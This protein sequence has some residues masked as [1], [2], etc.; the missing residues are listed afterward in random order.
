MLFNADLVEG[1]K[2]C[3]DP[4]CC[5]TRQQQHRVGGKM[6][7]IKGRYSSACSKKLRLKVSLPLKVLTLLSLVLSPLFVISSFDC[8]WLSKKREAF[9]QEDFP[10]LLRAEEALCLQFVLAKE[11]NSVLLRKKKF[12]SE[13]KNAGDAARFARND[14]GQ[15]KKHIYFLSTSSWK[16]CG[17]KMIWSIFFFQFL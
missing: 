1:R 8:S 6:H 17:L 12:A 9:F 10:N 11:E 13:K 16:N 15:Q 2:P 7:F 5:T 3:G 4:H 14:L